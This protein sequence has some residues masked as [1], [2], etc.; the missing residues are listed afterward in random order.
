MAEEINVSQESQVETPVVVEIPPPV[1]L[2]ELRYTYQP[3]DGEG[4][5]LGGKQVIKYKTAEELG[6]KL[7]EQN[8]LLIRK[9]RSET[10]KNR[11]GI[12]DS[13]EIPTESPKFAEPISFSPV[14]LTAEQKIQISRD[15]L[16]PEKSEEA[17]TALVTARF[18]ADPEKVTRALADVQNTNIRIL[19][20]MESDAFVA[21]NP[22]YVKC[23]SN[24]EAITSWM[25]RYDLAPV[26][27][28]FQ[29]AY[30]KLKAAGNIM[31]LSYAGVPEEERV[32]QVVAPVV[33]TQAE[34]AVPVQAIPA[35]VAPVVV[36]PVAEIPAVAGI[37]S[38][39]TRHNSDS[40]A[41]VKPA[42]DELIYEVES[43]G[44]KRTYTGLAAINAMP[45]EVYK[46]WILSDPK[47]VLLEKQLTDEADARRA[48]KRQQSQ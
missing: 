33:P 27:E 2:P 32:A 16:D 9:L 11:L 31:I 47:H 40:S 37:G 38:G 29:L 45:A 5:P 7:A 22:D 26:R 6:D 44:T 34:S 36:P 46:R 8:T 24:F 3:V 42:G 28:N 13:D 15:L 43:K 20:K 10:R 25:V 12:S 23:Q 19:A 39:F 17:A 1:E 41:P 14:E 35:V 18:G 21:A 4:R 48:L 30:D